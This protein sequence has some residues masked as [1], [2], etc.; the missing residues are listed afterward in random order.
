MLGDAMAN[1]NPDMGNS[2]I[3]NSK[4]DR[5]ESLVRLDVVWIALAERGGGPASPC[6]R[7]T[8]DRLC[9]VESDRASRSMQLAA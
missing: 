1:A 8:R 2:N 4:P 7:F 9:T 6:D 5:G 3:A